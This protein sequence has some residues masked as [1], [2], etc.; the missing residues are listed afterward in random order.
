L[1]GINGTAYGPYIYSGTALSFTNA[2]GSALQPNRNVVLSG[3]AHVAFPTSGTIRLLISVGDMAG[4]TGY[5]TGSFTTRPVCSELQ[6][7]DPISLQ[8]G[9]QAPQLYT[10][11]VISFTGGWN[12]QLVWTP[13]QTTGYLYCGTTGA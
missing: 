9:S 2:G 4:S 1:S 6:C 10:G 13:G 7:C 3:S 11:T 12:P 5:W 8:L